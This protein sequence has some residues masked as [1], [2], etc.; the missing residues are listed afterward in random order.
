MVRATDTGL[1]KW[2]SLKRY[3]VDAYDEERSETMLKMAGQSL[4]NEAARYSWQKVSA[5][6][7]EGSAFIKNHLADLVA[8][9]NMPPTFGDDFDAIKSSFETL[10]TNFLGGVTTTST[11][12]Q[13][14]IKANNAVYAK[15]SK[16]LNDGQLIF[17]SDDVAK[18]K[19]IFGNIKSVVSGINAAGV[20]GYVT[21]ANTGLPIADVTV[22]TANNVY[23]AVTDVEGRF[24]IKGMAAND[25][26]LTIAAEGYSSQTTTVS[27]K[28]GTT[29]SVTIVLDVLPTN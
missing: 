17:A 29:S 8:N 10:Q 16:M 7:D 11:N 3:I 1:L 2:R 4:Y 15:L 14:K 21:A 18:Q 20:R 22:A 24:D 19:F 12:T 27:V 9:N 5:L 23:T 6:M 25:Y 13:N 26:V 28:T